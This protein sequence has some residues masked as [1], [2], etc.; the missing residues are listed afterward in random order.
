MAV[1]CNRRG[2]A[3]ITAMVTAVARNV[4]SQEQVR[5]RLLAD[6]VLGVPV[7]P[8]LIALAAGSLLV[9]AVSGFRAPKRARQVACGGQGSYAVFD[10]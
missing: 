10:T 8:I 5:A 3:P 4:A 6:E 1:F 9:L 2:E 7:R